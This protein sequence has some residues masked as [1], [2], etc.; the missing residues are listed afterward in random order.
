MRDDKQKQMVGKMKEV[1]QDE[2]VRMSV[3][4]Y[5]LTEDL[6][7][8]TCTI[9][10]CLAGKNG[11]EFHV[12]GSGVGEIDAFFSGLRDRLADDHPSLKTIRFSAFDI[13]GLIEAEAGPNRSTQAEAKATVGILNSENREFTFETTAPSVSQAGLEAT[14]KAA[15][16]FVNSE[17]T[18]VRLHEILEHYRSEGR[19]DLVEKYTDL[20]SKVVENTSYSEVVERIQ[21]DMGGD[22][23]A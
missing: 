7:E 18:Y 21:N 8:G 12:E 5:T 13:E 2:Y 20:M 16:Y 17:K 4:N 23:S 6:E 19:M 1:L 3:K 22:E 9:Q 10:C 15:E 14:L 11:D